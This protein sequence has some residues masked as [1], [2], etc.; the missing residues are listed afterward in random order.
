MESWWP[1]VIM[2]NQEFQFLKDKKSLKVYLLFQVIFLL[3]CCCCFLLIGKII[4]THSYKKP[5]GYEDLNVL[6]VGIGNSGGDAA[7]EL[8][9]L[10]KNC[11]LST[12][13]GVWMLWR[14]G[15]NGM[16]FDSTYMKRYLDYLNR[17]TP[18]SIKSSIAE[19]KLNSRFNHKK[20]GLKP[21]HRV[22]SQHP[23]INDALP[24]RILSG[25][26][27]IKGD[28]EEFVE[29]GV[30]FKGESNITPINAVI[31]ATGYEVTFPFLDESIFISKENEVKLY[32]Y[33]FNPNLPHPHTLAFIGLIQ[34]IGPAIPVSEMQARWYVHLMQGKTLC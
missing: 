19:N 11:Y 28:I 8:S 7:V 12:R 14:V 33:M 15:P 17:I 20:Y 30:I 16:P 27:I 34:A 10:A 31:L 21:D 4:H 32:K 6:V 1:L 5:T 3:T 29:N 26:V 23:M 25:T 9:M 24:N 13:R 18:L 22:F 2:S